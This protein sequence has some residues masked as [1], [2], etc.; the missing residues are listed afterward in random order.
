[1]SR[2]QAAH[3]QAQARA[4]ESQTEAHEARRQ[5]QERAQHLEVELSRQANAVTKEAEKRRHV[6]RELA[7]CSAKERT[8][9]SALEEQQREIQQM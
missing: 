2:L 7:T 1:M 4:D 5:A 3:V 8:A 6:Q 9:R